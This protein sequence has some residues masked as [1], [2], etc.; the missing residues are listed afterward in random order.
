[1]LKHPMSQ[2][3]DTQHDFNDEVRKCELTLYLLG[4]EKSQQ[5]CFHCYKTWPWMHH[6]LS[7]GILSVR[8]VE[9]NSY[10]HDDLTYCT[11]SECCERYNS[12]EVIFKVIQFRWDIHCRKLSTTFIYSGSFTETPALFCRNALLTITKF[13]TFTPTSCPVWPAGHWAA[14][15]ER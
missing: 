8:K 14:S 15:L 1:M 12:F 9:H 13:H 7:A 4:C 5:L 6:L 10:N 11:K 3:K 2:N